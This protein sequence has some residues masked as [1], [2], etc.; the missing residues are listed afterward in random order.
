LLSR[1]IV[2]ETAMD[3]RVRILWSVITQSSVRTAQAC[4]AIRKR[5][6]KSRERLIRTR[7]GLM[8]WRIEVT[9]MIFLALTLEPVHRNIW[10]V[11]R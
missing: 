2:T 11:P 8:R 9:A 4:K 3:A 5:L 1:D 10:T 6:Q 7:S